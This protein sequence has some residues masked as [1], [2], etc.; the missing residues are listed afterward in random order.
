MPMFRFRKKATQAK[1]KTPASQASS[2]EW[3]K[4]YNW[5][6]LL[7]PILLGGYYLYQMDELLPI[8]SIQLSGSFENL[9]QGEVEQALQQYIGQGFFSLDIHQLQQLLHQKSWTESVSV[10]RVWPD[11]IRVTITE[12]KPVARWDERHLLSDSASVYLAD[13]SGFAHLPIV[14]ADSHQPAW[15]LRQFHALEARFERV[16]ERLLAL[17][18]DS[19]GA[20]DI[21]LINGLQI[22]LGRSD[23]ERKIERL[24]SIYLQQ[25][26]PRREQIQRLDLRYSNGFAVAWKQEVLQ[27][28]DK[29]SIWSN[30]NV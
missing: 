25:I 5:V 19:R 30:S 18:V 2:F 28:R 1:R 26:L 8:R 9:D 16:D 12:K 22:K 7:L 10:R 23:I 4:S 20:L 6:F 13:T 11:K 24:T 3:R 15:A 29:A 27:G 21:E 14:H 17:R